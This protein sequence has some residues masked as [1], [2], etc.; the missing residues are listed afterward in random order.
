MPVGTGVITMTVYETLP[1]AQVQCLDYS[2][3]MIAFAR[4]RANQSG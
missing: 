2:E 3:E 4:Q 1:K